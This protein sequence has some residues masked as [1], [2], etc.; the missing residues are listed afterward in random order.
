MKPS[1]TPNISYVAKI[2][3]VS[4]QNYDQAGPLPYKN[5]QL[6]RV[7]SVPNYRVFSSI[8]SIF[9]IGVEVR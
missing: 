3:G 1:E 2:R 5:N 6:T 9:K 8:S 7:K 4:T